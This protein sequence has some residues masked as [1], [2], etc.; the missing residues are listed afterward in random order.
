MWR[1][2]I[3]EQRNGGTSGAMEVPTKPSSLPHA[4]R[5]PELS[6]Q[7]SRWQLD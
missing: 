7:P 4:L 5:M 1:V 6:V 2:E 3:R